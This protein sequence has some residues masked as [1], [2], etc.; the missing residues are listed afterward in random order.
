MQPTDLQSY[1]KQ[2]LRLDAHGQWWHAGERFTNQKLIQLFHKA[3]FF[4]PAANE[5]RLKIGQQIGSFTY[6]DVPLFVNRI[7]TD[8]TPW[9]IE[10]ADGSLQIFSPSVLWLGSEQ[11]IYTEL[12][13]SK[14]L[15]R[16]TRSAH[17][18]LATYANSTSSFL[19]EQAVVPVKPIDE[20][21]RVC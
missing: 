9:Q 14:L 10:L 1:L 21:K 3:I 15:A 18:E 5:F 2:T 20:R 16:F 17:Q 7:R 12:V 11:Q 8:L 4:D 19:I 6:D 13:P